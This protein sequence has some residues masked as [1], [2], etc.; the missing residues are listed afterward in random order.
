MAEILV[1]IDDATL[2]RAL[3]ESQEQEVSID[4]F[5]CDAL[6]NSLAEP[7]SLSLRKPVNVEAL[8]ES[9]VEAACMKP[10]GVEFMLIDLVTN[11]AWEA[12]SGG[13]RKSLGKGFRK[14][15]EARVPAVAEFVR[16]TSSNKAV[17]KKI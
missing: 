3:T 16:R 10:S 4:V 11:E 1:K 9:A 14:A 6:N 12:L 7:S 2:L 5:I 8:I 17:Y 13:E 15:V